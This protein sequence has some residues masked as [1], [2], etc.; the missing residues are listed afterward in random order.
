MG[1]LA[2]PPADNLCLP[3]SGLDPPGEKPVDLFFEPVSGAVVAAD[4]H[5]DEPQLTPGDPVLGQPT[6]HLGLA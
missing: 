5:H 4:L 6:F 1:C 3:L 2:P